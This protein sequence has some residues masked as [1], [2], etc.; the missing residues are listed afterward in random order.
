MAKKPDAIKIGKTGWVL[1]YDN[2]LLQ[3]HA[4]ET[5]GKK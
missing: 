1:S 4:Y 3:I 2:L 5:P